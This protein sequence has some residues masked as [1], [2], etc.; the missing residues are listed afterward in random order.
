MGV[1]V[2]ILIPLVGYVGLWL[3]GSAAFL[4]FFRLFKVALD[5][6][7]PAAMI[8]KLPAPLAVPTVPLCSFVS[9]FTV[10]N[11]ILPSPA[12]V[13]QALQAGA[14]SLICTVVLDL[15]ITVAGERID[16]R[17]FPLNL[18][19]LFAWIVIIPAVVL[20]RT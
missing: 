2:F 12:R 7:H 5:L 11:A 4:V 19:Y 16:I 3:L 18:M 10:A 17:A 14:A 1:D 9:F 13:I 15:L 20:A 8:R 6:R